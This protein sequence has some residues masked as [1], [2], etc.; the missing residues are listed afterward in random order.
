M[1][2]IICKNY[3][4]MS[5]RAAS[6]LL[7]Q[8]VTKPNSILG[9]ATG[10]TPLG[11]YKEL[12]EAYSRGEADFSSV[13]SFNLDEYLGIP[14]TDPNS[15]FS[16]MQQNLFRHINLLKENTHLP[17]G[18]AA[19]AQEECK[20]YD[21][22]IEKAGG[23]DLQILGIGHDGHIGFNEPGEA[24]PE[25]THVETLTEETRAANARFFGSLDLVPTQA[26]TMG[27][28]TI[29]KAHRIILMASG[30]DKASIIAQMVRGPITPRVPA[31]ILRFHQN[32]VVYLDELAAGEI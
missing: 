10:S 30:K 32:T 31:S 18:M 24:F 7:A 9:L 1:K 14:N 22:L 21:L 3:D 27:I 17:N 6:L 2:V 11:L 26:V 23:V 8:L 19:N 28:G 4:D 12:I 16:F 13:I 25:G 20:N 5:R 29:M 15:Y